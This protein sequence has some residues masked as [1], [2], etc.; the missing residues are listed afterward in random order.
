MSVAL[1]DLAIRISTV[2]A[3]LC[4][5]LLAAQGK[6]AVAVDFQ[7]DA[8]RY[9]RNL[10]RKT[11]KVEEDLEKVVAEFGDERFGFLSWRRFDP[12][13]DRA[14][15]SA[16]L[17]IR[18][19]EG[20][21]GSLGT[22]IWLKFAALPEEKGKTFDCARKRLDRATFAHLGAVQLFSGAEHQSGEEN[23]LRARVER[24]LHYY[25]GNDGFR[26]SFSDAFLHRIPLCHEVRLFPGSFEKYL[27]LGLEQEKLPLDPKSTMKLKPC[28]RLPGK[29]L[30]LGDIDLE[31]AKSRVSEGE[32]AS[33]V[34]AKVSSC[35]FNP[36]SGDACM[37]AIPFILQN[38]LP[39][40]LD[41]FMTRYIGVVANTNGPL[42]TRP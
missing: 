13:Q 23:I 14:L 10:Y 22:S 28:S 36:L 3:L 19:V 18:M 31:L 40:G 32:L 8:S 11:D 7:I 20:T 15:L 5:T 16:V 9:Q 2:L 33:L 25:F 6:P 39:D 30:V 1:R 35:D 38:K 41:V 17:T 12:A 37:E 24:A 4:P 21:P 26:Q 27:A 34:Q 29:D 42:A